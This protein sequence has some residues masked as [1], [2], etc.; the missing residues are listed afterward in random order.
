[1]YIITVMSSCRLC[2]DVLLKHLIS[3]VSMFLASVLFRAQIS[4]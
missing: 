2:P 4:D 1:M 3:T